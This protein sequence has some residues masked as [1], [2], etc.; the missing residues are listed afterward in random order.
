MVCCCPAGLSVFCEVNISSIYPPIL[1]SLH[2][3]V[4]GHS[5]Y[6]SPKSHPNR[7]PRYRVILIFIR[8]HPQQSLLGL[9]HSSA[10]SESSLGQIPSVFDRP[11]R[12]PIPF[13][14]SNLCPHRT[15]PSHVIPRLLSQLSGTCLSRSP[16]A[17]LFYTVSLVSI[18]T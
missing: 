7:S 18:L 5:I 8:H 4:T 10:F 14:L 2:H 17:L 1:L 13:H 12:H 11:T 15:F 6:Y 9:S 16:V 3:S